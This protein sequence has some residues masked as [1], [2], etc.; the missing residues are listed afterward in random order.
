VGGVA[1]LVAAGIGLVAMSKL[2]MLHHRRGRDHEPVDKGEPL[3]KA[4]MGLVTDGD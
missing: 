2:G 1:C 4:P 3:S